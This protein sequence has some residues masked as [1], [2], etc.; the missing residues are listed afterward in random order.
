IKFRSRRRDFGR[1]L[2]GSVGCSQL[3]R[4]ELYQRISH[5]RGRGRDLAPLRRR[6]L[7]ASRRQ[8]GSRITSPVATAPAPANRN[9]AY[10]RSAIM[11]AIAVRAPATYTNRI[12]LNLFIVR[13]RAGELSGRNRILVF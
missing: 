8:E 10:P 5:F 9:G 12:T 3:A 6:W 2:G 1:G 7:R 11:T 4:T 13:L